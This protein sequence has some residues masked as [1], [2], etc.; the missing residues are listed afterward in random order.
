MALQTIISTLLGIGL[1]PLLAGL[2]SDA[3]QPAFGI[4]SL[5]YALLLV[6]LP[7][8][9]AIMLLIRTASHAGQNRYMHAERAA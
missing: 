4:E 3:L 6:S 7:V 1:G 5:R 9:G 2:L 8:A